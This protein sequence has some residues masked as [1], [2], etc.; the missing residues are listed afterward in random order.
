MLQ[1]VYCPAIQIMRGSIDSAF[2]REGGDLRIITVFSGTAVHARLPRVKRGQLNVDCFQRKTVH[3]RSRCR[4]CSPERFAKNRSSS[5]RIIRHGQFLTASWLCFISK[6]I[7]RSDLRPFHAAVN[8]CVSE[9]VVHAVPVAFFI[10]NDVSNLNRCV[11]RKVARIGIFVCF[12]KHSGVFCNGQIIADINLIAFRLFGF[13]FFSQFLCR[14]LCFLRTIDQRLF[15]GIFCLNFCFFRNVCFDNRFIR[16]SCRFLRLFRFF[17][18]LRVWFFG[19]NRFFSNRLFHR[20]FSLFRFFCSRFFRDF[21]YRW[22]FCDGYRYSRCNNRSISRN[23]KGNVEIFI[24]LQPAVVSVLRPLF[25]FF[26]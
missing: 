24:N 17:H 11:T 23:D 16:R 8:Q 25:G 13:R 6:D 18:R 22:F 12:Q 5:Q 21:L 15:C 2:P 9:H 4:L 7:D 10:L 3:G 26:V 20:S 19:D 14:H 1:A